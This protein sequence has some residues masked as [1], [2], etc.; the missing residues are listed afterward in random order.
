MLAVGGCWRCS[1]DEYPLRP[2]H[3]PPDYIDDLQSRLVKVKKGI[4]PP[5]LKIIL[6]MYYH[7]PARQALV[8]SPAA[9]PDNMAGRH[10]GY[11][12]L[13]LHSLL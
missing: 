9:Q 6:K 5:N 8:T 4:L 11:G 12:H 13:G 7:L 2:L 3:I 10:R 1:Q